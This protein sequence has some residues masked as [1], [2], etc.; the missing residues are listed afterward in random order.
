MLLLRQRRP[1]S[2]ENES[3]NA[4]VG[5]RST[6]KQKVG[7]SELCK[8]AAGAGAAVPDVR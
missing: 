8:T 3:A 4:A 1:D 5:T 7:Q 6:N 2:Q